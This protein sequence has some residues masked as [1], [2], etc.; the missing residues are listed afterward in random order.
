MKHLLPIL[1]LAL[2]TSA[3]STPE[4]SGIRSPELFRQ[5]AIRHSLASNQ[6]AAAVALCF[7]AEATLLPMSDIV[8]DEKSGRATYRLR[9]FGFTFEEIDFE[10]TPN[11]SRMTVFIA[12]NMNAKW[13][14][15]FERDRGIPLGACA[16][17]MN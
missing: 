17:S 16:G 7:E 8:R 3:C 15:D 1:T 9:G 6:P 10:P 5:V 2:A 12:P 13:H 4:P 11:G 14:L